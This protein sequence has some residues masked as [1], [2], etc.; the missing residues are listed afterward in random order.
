VVPAGQR[1]EKMST[2]TF[3]TM[4]DVIDYIET[5]IGPEYVDDFDVVG[6][7]HSIT[8]WKDGKLCLSMQ[9]RNFWDV[10]CEFELS[11]WAVS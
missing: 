4:Q 10:V 6:I 9:G 8:K 1:G 3:N 5:A 2:S 11:K 7:A